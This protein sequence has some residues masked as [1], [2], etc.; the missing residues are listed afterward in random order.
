VREVELLPSA[1]SVPQARRFARQALEGS[2]SDVETAVLLVSELV[3]NAVLHARSA[4]RLVIDDRG[5]TARVEVHDTSP[6]Q[7]RVQHYRLTSGT[8]RGLRMVA[9]LSATWGVESAPRGEGKVVWFEIGTPSDDR[10]EHV[11]DELLTEVV[12]GEH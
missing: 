5:S 9:R 2:T 1:D 11:G 8:G 12:N 3:T 6:L 4:I 7:P 10:W